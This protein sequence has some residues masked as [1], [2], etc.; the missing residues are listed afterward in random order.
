MRH[1]TRLLAKLSNLFHGE[2]AERDL[3]RE[4]ETHLALLQDEYQRSGMNSRDARF[5]ALRAYGGVEQASCQS[6]EFEACG[7]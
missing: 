3:N 4:I 1:W 5:R 7:K 6:T 2:C